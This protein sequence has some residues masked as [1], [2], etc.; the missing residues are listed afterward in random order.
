[1]LAR[2]PGFTLTAVLTL[3]L[4][5]SATTTMMTVVDAVLVK[6]LPYVAPERLY[7]ATTVVTS[8]PYDSAPGRTSMA[9]SLKP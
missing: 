5:V 6:P 9:L 8:E 4:G 2:T 1:M 7:L 3:A